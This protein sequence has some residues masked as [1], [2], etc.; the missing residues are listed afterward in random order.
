MCSDQALN[1]K[2]PISQIDESQISGATNPDFL[3]SGIWGHF[4]GPGGH[5]RDSGGQFRNINEIVEDF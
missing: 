5:F 4:R 1:W 2:P 3:G